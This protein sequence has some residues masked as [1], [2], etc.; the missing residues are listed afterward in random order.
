M[1]SVALPEPPQTRLDA[2]LTDPD[3]LVIVAGQTFGL[4][5]VST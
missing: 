4:P 5:G 2:P 1:V 3:V